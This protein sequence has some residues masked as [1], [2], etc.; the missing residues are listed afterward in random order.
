MFRIIAAI[1]CL[2][3]PGF[4]LAQESTRYIS[5]DERGLLHVDTRMGGTIAVCYTASAL[6][7]TSTRT[8]IVVKGGRL[9]RAGEPPTII[10][11]SP[12][13]VSGLNF[14]KVR[15]KIRAR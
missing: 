1:C 13:V 3:L 14:N 2:S 7:I 15:M 9:C 11:T 12:N 4:A 8:E 6:N 5:V 10:I